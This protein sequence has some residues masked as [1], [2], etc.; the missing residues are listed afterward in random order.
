ME[1]LGVIY[2]CVNVFEE[3]AGVATLERVL[4]SVSAAGV[5]T[6]RTPTSPCI[7]S[8][9]GGPRDNLVW[10]TCAADAHCNVYI[11]VHVA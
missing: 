4:N 2:D 6:V 9:L 10:S 5:R 1:N 7:G 8:E 3:G 11:N